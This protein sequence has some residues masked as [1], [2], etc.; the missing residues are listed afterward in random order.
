M[1]L[2]ALEAD[3]PIDL[4]RI[5]DVAIRLQLFGLLSEATRAKEERKS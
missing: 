4:E 1:C 2:A 5:V 3:A